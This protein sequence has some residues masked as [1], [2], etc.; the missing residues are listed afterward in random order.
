MK[1]EFDHELT[2]QVSEKSENVLTRQII[3]F[4]VIVFMLKFSTLLI[5]AGQGHIYV[6]KRTLLETFSSPLLAARDEGQYSSFH[7]CHG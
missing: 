5:P 1:R 7:C 2:S 6:N 3:V 4:M